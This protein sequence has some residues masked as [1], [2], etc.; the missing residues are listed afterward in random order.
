M[1]VCACSSGCGGHLGAHLA[2][3]EPVDAVEW[4]NLRRLQPISQV[5]G[6]DRGL[7]IDRYYLDDFLGSHRQD[8]RGRVIEVKDPLCTLIY[9]DD[10][11]QSDVVDVREDNPGATVIADL[12]QPDSLPAQAYD[13][14]VLTQ[15][16]H[17]VYE[18]AQVVANAHR[19]LR[20]GG[21]LLA[22][23]PCVSRIDPESGLDADFW[24]FTSA[25]ATR[26]FGDVF[27]AENVE[28][29]SYGNVLACVGFLYG[30]AAGELSEEELRH[31]DPYFPL[32]LC[33]RAIRAE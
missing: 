21:V 27:G 6:L 17:V 1:S 32:L 7:P 5:W 15:T 16:I 19:T 33:V 12:S 30:L 20:P 22:S 4:G 28:V 23:L 3:N 11:K 24:R 31:C 10:V 9:G 2:A 29:F 13:C 26:L 8:I 25:S 18:A 14:F